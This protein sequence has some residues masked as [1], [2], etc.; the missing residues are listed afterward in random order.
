MVIASAFEVEWLWVQ[1]VVV[2]SVRK[3]LWSRC[4]HLPLSPGSIIRYWPKGE[5]LLCSWEG[6]G[7]PDRK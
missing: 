7:G 4:S 1:L 6:N 5:F 3:Q 2:F